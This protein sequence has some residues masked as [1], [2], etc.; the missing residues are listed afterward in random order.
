MQF[1]DFL[2][3]LISPDLRA[4]AVHWNAARAGR[5][6]P[7]WR[8]LQPARMAAQLTLV[9]TFKY[10]GATNRFTGRLAGD[11]ISRGLGRS[12]RG[13]RLEE[14][15]PPQSLPMIQDIM[16]RVV[17]D[18]AL[19]HLNGILFRQKE[20]TGTGER[21]MLPLAEDGAHGDGVL[22]ASVVTYPFADPGYAP[23]ELLSEGED[24]F[25]LSPLAAVA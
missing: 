23:I 20:R 25:V 3:T 5:A 16:E 19:Y 13:I 2:D 8:Q 7:S 10:D 21:I 14:L 11:R 12:F 9:W 4:V 22:G 18:P 6:M 15:H 1:A 24:W 17:R